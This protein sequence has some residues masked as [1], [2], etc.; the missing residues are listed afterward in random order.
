[1]SNKDNIQ[2]LFFIIPPIVNKI[3]VDILRDYI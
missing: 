3:T 1:M 2:I